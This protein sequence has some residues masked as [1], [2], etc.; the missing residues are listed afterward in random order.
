[1]GALA[2]RAKSII[3][4]SKL[5]PVEKNIVSQT[6]LVASCNP[7]NAAREILRRV[8]D[9]SVPLEEALRGLKHDWYRVLELLSKRTEYGVFGFAPDDDPSSDDMNDGV[10]LFDCSLYTDD[11]AELPLPNPILLKIHSLFAKAPEV[12]DAEREVAQPWP[13]PVSNLYWSRRWQL[14]FR[15]VW[16]IVPVFI[17]RWSY[18]QLINRGQQS[19]ISEIVYSLPLGLYAKF[20]GDTQ[21]EPAALR[22][23]ETHASSV[24]S[25]LFVDLMPLVA[26]GKPWLI[27]TGMPGQRLDE[28]I[29]KMSYPERHQ[30]ADDLAAAIKAYRNVPNSSNFLIASASGGRLQDPRTSS[31]GCGPYQNESDFNKQITRGCAQDLEQAFPDAHSRRYPI[32]FTHADL[33]PSNILIDS[34]R[35]SGIVDWQYAGFYPAYWEYTKAM[36]SVRH[37]EHYQAI[38]RRIFSEYEDELEVEEFLSSYFPIWGPSEPEAGETVF[39]S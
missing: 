5:S 30:L 31:S 32:V 10:R 35:L 8:E 3:A 37:A 2:D 21:G 14:L 27:M 11:P 7:E 36:R 1:M 38:F 19:S 18:R 34:G 39:P 33:F 17:R 23:L 16:Y 24:P 9:D 28:V 25:P 29:H 6:F 22:L 13:P 26:D 4:S 12:N 20:C 15:R